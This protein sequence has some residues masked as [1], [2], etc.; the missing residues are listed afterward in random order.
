SRGADRCP[1]LPQVL[2][3]A[4][5]PYQVL[6]HLRPGALIESP[7][8][9]LGEQLDDVL[10][11]RIL[12]PDLA[13]GATSVAHPARACRTLVRARC[14]SPRWLASLTCTASHTSDESQSSMSLRVIT[15]R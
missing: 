12:R 6:L 11:D 9:E 2:R 14:R 1:E 10:A 13:H 7:V 3:A 4:G 15:C 8:H 5:A